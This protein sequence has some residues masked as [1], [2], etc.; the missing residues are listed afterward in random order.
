[1][2]VTFCSKCGN[3]ETS[4]KSFCS[5]CG[6]NLLASNRETPISPNRRSNW[7]YLLSIIMAPIGA[8]IT[9]FVIRHDDPEKAKNCLIIG[10]IIF[11]FGLV[12]GF[13]MS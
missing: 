7:W 11:V 1:M 13:A 5:K 3:E 10:F 8:I 6:S 2:L 4:G 9:Y 12:M